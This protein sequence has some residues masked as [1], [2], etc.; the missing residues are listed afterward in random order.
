M[1]GVINPSVS[2]GS[3]QRETSVTC[4]PMVIVPSGAAGA[5]ETQA[6]TMSAA[7]TATK[8]KALDCRWGIS[9][10]PAKVGPEAASIAGAARHRELRG[11]SSPRLDRL[12]RGGEC[13]DHRPG[14]PPTYPWS[15]H[16]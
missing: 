7:R 2:A 16:R 12:D 8:G 10:P 9:I 1:N 14:P 13:E 6:R 4:T 11:A 3:S 5:G 15:F